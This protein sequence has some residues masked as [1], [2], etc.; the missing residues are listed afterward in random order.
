MTEPQSHSAVADKQEIAELIYR[1]CRAVDRL[2]S[3]LGHSIWHADGTAD[4]GADYYQGPGQGVIDRIC[5]DHGGLLHHSHQVTN[6]LIELDGDAAGSESY[7]FANLRMK[8]GEALTQMTVWT[9]YIDRWSRRDGC[10]GIDH[11]QAVRDFDEVREVT[12]MSDPQIARRGADDP[13]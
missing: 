3:A 2:D 4:Y 13:S 12:P 9:R 7:C 11:R 6:I 5:R 8:R 10:W 1:Y